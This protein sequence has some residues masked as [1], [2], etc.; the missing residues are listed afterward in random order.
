MTE[1]GKRI[2]IAVIGGGSVVFSQTLIADILAGSTKR[3]DFVLMAPTMARTSPIARWAESLIT[4]ACLPATV[5]VVT[6][7]RTALRNADYV[8]ATFNIGGLSATELDYAIPRRYGVDQCIGD[9]LGPGGIFRA[10]RAIPV[11]VDLARNMS[12]LCPRALLLNY[13]NPMA[14]VCWALGHSPITTVGLCHGVQVS[15]DLIA[16]YTGVPKREIDYRSAGINHMAWFVRLQHR[17][18]DLY[19]LLRERFEDPAYYAN[20]KVRGEVLR[21]IGYFMTESTAHLSEYLPY[22]R[23]TQAARDQYCDEPDSGAASGAEVE[24]SRMVVK[25]WGAAECVDTYPALPAPSTEYGPRIIEALEGGPPFHFQGNVIN[26]GMITNLPYDCCVEGPM[27][28]DG[29]GLQKVLVGELPNVCAALNLT[30]IN[31]QRLAVE[32]ALTGDPEALVHACALD[33]LTSAVLTLGEIRILASEMLE[34]QRE[35]L[36]QFGGR[37]ISTLPAIPIPEGTRR[38]KLPLDP[39]LAVAAR[40]G[41]LAKAGE[42]PASHEKSGI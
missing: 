37:R 8:F 33:P 6:D 36:P 12:E 19:P 22:F 24:W 42:I 15:L 30:N 25:N 4:T 3:V 21:H 18:R 38:V 29:L 23:K 35:W 10:Q 27:T 32:A 41:Q 31:V 1:N 2:R 13:V 7:Q 16:H 5:S 26:R 17:G 34:A 9:T 20:E 14:M 39:A 40:F 28:A 11:A